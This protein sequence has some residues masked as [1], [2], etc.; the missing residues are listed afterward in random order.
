[1]LFLRI[2]AR[3]INGNRIIAS[4]TVSP[5]YIAP[6]GVKMTARAARRS[7]QK[8]RLAMCCPPHAN[9]N[10]RVS[11]VFVYRAAMSGKSFFKAVVSTL[12]LV[13]AL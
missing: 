4:I 9:V 13:T 5:P 1:M 11:V 2:S 12:E 10:R 7:A 8:C 3:T 6:G